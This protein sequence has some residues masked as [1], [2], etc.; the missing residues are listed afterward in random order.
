MGLQLLLEH[1]HQG[2]PGGYGPDRQKTEDFS[3][4]RRRP[5]GEYGA[6]L[7][8]ESFN[9]SHS[10]QIAVDKWTKDVWTR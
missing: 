7:A 9:R 3:K 1:V 4:D 6:V 10:Y 5:E 8:V 2:V